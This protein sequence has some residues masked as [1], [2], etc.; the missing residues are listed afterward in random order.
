[1]AKQPG[2]GE[3]SP[4]DTLAQAIIQMEGSMNPGSINMS[5]VTQYGLWNVG[6]LVWAGQTGAQKLW[7]KDRN[8]AAWPSYDAAYAGLV[9]D[10]KAKARVGHTIRTGMEK[11]APPSENNTE[12]YIAFVSQQTGYPDSTPLSALVAADPGGQ[13][14][15]P[16]G[17]TG[18]EDLSPTESP[19]WLTDFLPD[20]AALSDLGINPTL[21]VLALGL[22]AA[23]LLTKVTRPRYA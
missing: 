5:M 23:V 15:P 20:S 16:F 14:A 4:L 22:G 19:N 6:H 12:R 10:L 2:L 9:R 21:L 1:M 18:T 8:W 11:Y 3:T 13:V 7:M 17:N